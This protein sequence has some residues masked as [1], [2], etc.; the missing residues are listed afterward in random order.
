MANSS[1]RLTSNTQASR[2]SGLKQSRCPVCKYSIPPGALFCPGCGPPQL[3]VED[4]EKG[5]SA[6]QASLRI[7]LIG[8]L[9][10]AVVAY[11]YEINFMDYLPDILP[12]IEPETRRAS[13]EDIKITYVINA[14]KTNIR[15]KRSLESKVVMVL[16]KGVVVSVLQRDDKWSQIQVDEKIGWVLN[17]RLV[18][19]AD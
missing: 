15:E 13:T 11:K 1:S 17:K 2:S 9:F 8:L 10:S 19:K 3:P 14:A 12:G 4:P 18:A 5:I 16:D 6:G 7:I